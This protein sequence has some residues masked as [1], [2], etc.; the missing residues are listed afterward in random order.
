MN[1]GYIE[2]EIS[3]QDYTLGALDATVLSPSGQWL[4]YLPEN[5]VQRKNGL[6]TQNCTV[7]GTLN[8]LEILLYKQKGVKHNFSERYG[9][10]MAGTKVG[11]NS[12]HKVI[13]VIRNYA[14]VID[15]VVL[16]FGPDIDTWDEYYSEVTFAHKIQGL[17]WLRKNE[18]LHEWVLNEEHE[19]W[20]NRLIRSLRYSP[21]GIAVQAWNNK[22]GV[23]VRSGPDTHWCVLVGY[24]EKE[25]WIVLDSYDKHLKKL[26]WDYGFTRAKRYTIKEREKV[27]TKFIL[28]ATQGLLGMYA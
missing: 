15:D 10:V 3:S 17:S 5:E 4:L 9:G 13:E 19:D 8:A 18:V 21:L 28:R 11:G 16:P 25:Y 14:G 12:P 22:N 26:A 20:Q 7:Y 27:T 1:Y 24:R 23:F 6:E 2:D